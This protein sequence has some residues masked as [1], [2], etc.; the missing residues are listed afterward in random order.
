LGILGFTAPP[1][2]YTVGQQSL[3]PDWK[4]RMIGFPA[5]M[6]LGTGMIWNNTR[7]VLGAVFD[8]SG[9]FRRTPKFVD[10]WKSS[11][12]ALASDRSIWIE[13]LLAFYAFWGMCAALTKQ[14]ALAPYLGLYAFAMAAVV[15]WGQWENWN[16]R[17]HRHVSPGIPATISKH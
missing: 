10:S 16:V 8:R 1:L 13:I 4:S 17:R 11:S 5:L 15:G 12:Y 14:P 2:L 6:V 9:E 3:Y 7:A